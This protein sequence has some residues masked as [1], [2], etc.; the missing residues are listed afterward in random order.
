MSAHDRQAE[1]E[2]ADFYESV[3]SAPEDKGPLYPRAKKF[4]EGF[5]TGYIM[6]SVIRRLL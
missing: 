6:A 1:R 3:R 5:F 4:G 2:V